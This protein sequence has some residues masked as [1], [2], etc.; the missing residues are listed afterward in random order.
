M[1]T[2]NVSLIIYALILDLNVLRKYILNRLRKIKSLKIC[3][4][5]LDNLFKNIKKQQEEEEK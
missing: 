3:F 2:Y 1:A 5:Y 4:N